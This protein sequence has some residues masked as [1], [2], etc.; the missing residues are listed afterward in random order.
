VIIKLKKRE[1]IFE[2]GGLKVIALLDPKEERIYVD[3]VRREIDNLYNMTSR[4]D[5]YINPTMDGELFWRSIS[6]CT[7]ELEEGI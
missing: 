7:S 2:G 5:D 4:M 1:M 6:T 3:P